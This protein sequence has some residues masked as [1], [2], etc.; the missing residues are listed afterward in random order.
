MRTH[1]SNPRPTTHSPA[2]A[3][4]R[5]RLRLVGLATLLLAAF[6][7]APAQAD[8]YFGGD[9]YGGGFEDP[10]EDGDVFDGDIAPAS[11]FYWAKTYGDTALEQAR[12]V[13]KT[14]DGGAIVAGSSSTG[15][16]DPRSGTV[17]KLD[18]WGGVEWFHYYDSGTDDSINDVRQTADGGYVAVGGRGCGTDCSDVWVM[19]LDASGGITWQK[20]YAAG[21][22][23]ATTVRQTSD[24]GFVVLAGETA[25]PE[26]GHP[27]AWVLKLD[28]WGWV[29]WQWSF[30]MGSA[31]YP[32][33][34]EVDPDG[35]YIVTGTWSVFLDN[36]VWVV[37][38]DSTGNIDWAGRYGGPRDDEA[39]AIRPTSG[40]YVVA[41]STDS[42]GDSTHGWLLKLGPR[43]S[44][45]WQKAYGGSGS[46]IFTDLAVTSDDTYI[47]TGIT[48][49]WGGTRVWLLELG[50]E[51]QSLWSRTWGGT[52][53]E[54]PPAVDVAWDGDITVAG[55]TGSY[56]AG[57]Y[58]NWILRLEPSGEIQDCEICSTQ[59]LVRRKTSAV[60]RSWGFGSRFTGVAGV[61]IHA[62][63]E[64]A[65]ILPGL[66]CQD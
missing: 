29:E 58:D 53:Y 1:N 42:F 14:W 31:T 24:G 43:G 21:D 64:V 8:D 48:N 44:L 36:D 32:S 6:A 11:G 56:G 15:W 50:H 9:F 59:A 5:R 57:S 34:I 25:W 28:S 61:S 22:G 33:S 52:W 19:K 27:R 7:V 37:K 13:Q 40:G 62:T 26:A 66:V 17:F 65:P 60:Q 10:W 18:A 63:V 3:I 54:Y 45:V 46:D 30:T 4:L 23:G 49:S 47:V 39:A 12:S 41:G 20:T 35:G 38:L 16:G 51:G 2:A 55:A